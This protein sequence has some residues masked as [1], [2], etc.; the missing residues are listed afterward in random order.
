MAGI[1]ATIVTRLGFVA[2]RPSALTLGEN[3]K[4]KSVAQ[5]CLPG[6]TLQAGSRMLPYLSPTH[7]CVSLNVLERT[8]AVSLEFPFSFFQEL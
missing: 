4:A 2:G 3:L 1:C 5:G 6:P 7:S 8:P